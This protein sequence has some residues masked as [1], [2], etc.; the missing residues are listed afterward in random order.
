MS[1]P[2]ENWEDTV[3]SSSAGS[4]LM[5]AMNSMKRLML[6]QRRGHAWRW[7]PPIPKATVRN[8]PVTFFHNRWSPQCQQLSCCYQTKMWISMLGI[9]GKG[10]NLLRHIPLST[11]IQ[12]LTGHNYLKYHC[13]KV[14]KFPRETCHFCGEECKEFA[15]L[16]CECPALTRDHL[17]SIHDLQLSTPPNLT[18]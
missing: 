3:R 5:W 16:A 2:W 13:S 18:H 7:W 4:W 9:M 8:L 6:W 12:A 1:N 17:A 11:V 10:I 15:H 14:N